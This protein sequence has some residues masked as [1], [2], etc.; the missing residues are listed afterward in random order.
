MR[1]PG[2]LKFILY[3]L[4]RMALGEFMDDLDLGGS[5]MDAIGLEMSDTSSADEKV[6]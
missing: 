4:K 5:V 6:G 2:T 3:E 1:F